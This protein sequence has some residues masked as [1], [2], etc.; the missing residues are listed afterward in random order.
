MGLHC[1]AARTC[2]RI[3]EWCRRNDTNSGR[4]CDGNPPW[5]QRCGSADGGE[6]SERTPPTLPRPCAFARAQVH[7]HEP[8]EACACARA[9]VR[10]RTLIHVHMCVRMCVRVCVCVGGGV[11]VCECMCVCARAPKQPLHS[12]SNCE[13]PVCV[14]ECVHA[15]ACVTPVQTAYWHRVSGARVCA[16]PTGAMRTNRDA[17]HMALHVPKRRKNG[18]K[19]RILVSSTILDLALVLKRSTLKAFW[20]LARTQLRRWR[21][22]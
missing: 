17:R 16:I 4:K 6:V 11:S 21:R 15:P 20:G 9:R 18:P 12:C 8:A 14:S 19:T 5:H 3:A 22:S 13:G 2:R 7:A 10:V 1:T